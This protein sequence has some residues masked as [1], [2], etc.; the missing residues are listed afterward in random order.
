MILIIPL[1][2]L[3]FKAQDNVGEYREKICIDY[4]VNKLYLSTRNFFTVCFIC[5]FRS[6]LTIVGKNSTAFS[7]LNFF[8]IC[9]NK[10]G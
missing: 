7:A 1:A 9:L 5:A 2:S 10:K 3:K 4:R 8:R 6:I